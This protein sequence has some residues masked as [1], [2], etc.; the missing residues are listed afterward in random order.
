M[1]AVEFVERFAHRAN[2]A[3]MAI[4]RLRSV[5]GLSDAFVDLNKITVRSGEG[6]L[7]MGA[8]LIEKDRSWRRLVITE[9]TS[10][11]NA[12]ERPRSTTR[13]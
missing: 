5:P 7:P 13:R 1:V 3:A 6:G 12:G 9:Q 11:R 4:R 10:E 2:L 8:A